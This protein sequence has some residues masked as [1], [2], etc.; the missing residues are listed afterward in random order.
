METKLKLKEGE[1]LNILIGRLKKTKSEV[2]I[3]LNISDQTLSK[4]FNSEFLTSNIK[5][6]SAAYLGVSES[7][8]SG[9]YVS[10]LSE[11]EWNV[12]NEPDVKY[13]SRIKVDE[14]TAGEVMRYLEEKDRRHY[15]ERARLLGIIENLTKS[16]WYENFATGVAVQCICIRAK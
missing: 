7:F 15:E 10:N 16:K 9:W 2:A 1:V 6:R 4:A 12:M 8:F 3:D 11:G 13:E 14:L 5:Q